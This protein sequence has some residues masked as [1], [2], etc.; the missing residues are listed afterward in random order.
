MAGAAQGNEQCKSFGIEV[1]NPEQPLD[2]QM[3]WPATYA[4]DLKREKEI[5]EL[6][7]IVNKL[8]EEVNKLES[9][10]SNIGI[11][12][13]VPKICQVSRA[14]DMEGVMR[15]KIDEE[16]ARLDLT[17]PDQASVRDYLVNH[18]D[19]VD[20]LPIVTEKIHQKFG[21][22]SEF[23]LKI[24]PDEDD[25]Y[26]AI[27]IRQPTYDDSVMDRIREIR[28]EYSPLLVNKSGWFLLTTDYLSPGAD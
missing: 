18:L 21:V 3:G 22:G 13:P 19:M 6:R 5:S 28:N 14:I 24:A 15:M 8:T 12:V 10:V 2:Y 26:I 25:E 9:I 4:V 23:S 7:T 11:V 16:L 20:I 17:I 27:T 1:R